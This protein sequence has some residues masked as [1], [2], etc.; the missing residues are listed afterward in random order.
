MFTVM[1]SLRLRTAICMLAVAIVFVCLIASRPPSKS[2]LNDVHPPTVN[3]QLVWGVAEQIFVISLPNRADRRAVLSPLWKAHQLER[4]QYVNATSVGEPEIDRILAHVR[5]ERRRRYAYKDAQSSR[6]SFKDGLGKHPG[7]LWGSDLWTLESL[8]PDKDF[9]DPDAA[10]PIPCERGNP[11]NP[12]RAVSGSHYAAAAPTE[13]VLRKIPLLSRPMIACWHSHLQVIRQISILGTT[14][15]QS[16]V[17]YSNHLN[18][19]T[20][21]VLEDDVDFEWNIKNFL[22]PI[23][24][25]LPSDWEV[26]MLG[27]F[28]LDCPN[29]YSEIDAAKVTAGPMSVATRLDSNC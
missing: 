4:I 7:E 26:V 8:S 12:H 10:Y 14:A 3:S 29:F 16:G 23:W 20:Y 9:L 18:G 28:H 21:I 17:K 13:M 22:S 19:R 11:F 24:D 2:Y 5:K 6:P 25:A 1:P 27:Q 15:E